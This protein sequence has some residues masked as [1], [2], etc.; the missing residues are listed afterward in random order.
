MQHQP[1]Q[2]S[3]DGPKRKPVAG[4]QRHPAAL[5]AIATEPDVRIKHRKQPAR[6]TGRLPAHTHGHR[7]IAVDRIHELNTHQTGRAR[8]VAKRADPH[9]LIDAAPV[10]HVRSTG[11]PATP[12]KVRQPQLRDT[13]ADVKRVFV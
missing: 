2:P 3:A 13:D 6:R 10:S 7:A 11:Q 8:H 1:V 4:G 9:Q 12:D 5:A